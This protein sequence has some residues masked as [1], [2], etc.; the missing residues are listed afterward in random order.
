MPSLVMISCSNSISK[1]NGCLN[2]RDTVSV[3]TK[4]VSCANRSL[5]PVCVVMEDEQCFSMGSICEAELVSCT[6]P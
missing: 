3:I 4:A 5:I 2:L 6:K 1:Y